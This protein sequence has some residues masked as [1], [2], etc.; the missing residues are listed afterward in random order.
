[1]SYKAIEVLAFC[2]S[3]ASLSYP[4]DIPFSIHALTPCLILSK[5]SITFS[6]CASVS[7]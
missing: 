6:Y 2:F 7:T 1:L 3:E 4:L 5:H